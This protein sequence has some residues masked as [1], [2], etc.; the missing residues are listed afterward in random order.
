MHSRCARARYMHARYTFCACKYTCVHAR[1]TH[2]RVY[3]CA[4]M[5]ALC[6]CVNT[7]VLCVCT[8]THARALCHVPVI[9]L[10]MSST[11]VHVHVKCLHNTFCACFLLRIFARLCTHVHSMHARVARAQSA[12]VCALCARVRC[13]RVHYTRACTHFMSTRV[14]TLALCTHV[15]VHAVPAFFFF[16]LHVYK[17]V[18][19]CT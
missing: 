4:C 13:T 2:T 7:C 10:C 19:A 18:H 1:S 5:H 3:T 9:H 6:T 11:C 16:S 17:H 8:C 14:Y 12:R 15:H